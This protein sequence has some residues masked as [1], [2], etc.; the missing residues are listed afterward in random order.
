MKT[1]IL[2]PASMQRCQHH[3]EAMQQL[4]RLQNQPLRVNLSMHVMS[5]H[6]H[7]CMQHMMWHNV[8]VGYA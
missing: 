6:G 4:Q 3:I 5:L 1:T 7:P 8:C 2:P